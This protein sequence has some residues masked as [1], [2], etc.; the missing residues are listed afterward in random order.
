[1]ITLYGSFAKKRTG[2]LLT[3]AA[4]SVLVSFLF[5]ASGCGS[6]T[7]DGI[8]VSGTVSAAEV[9]VS[10][11]TGGRITD[12]TVQEGV[13]VKRGE[14]L[15]RLDSKVQALQVN[16]AE[17]G[18]RAAVEKARETKSGSREQLIAQAEFTVNQFDSLQQGARHTMQNAG[19]TL[20]RLKR[21]FA[22]GGATQQQL[23][24]AETGLAAAKAQ[25]ESFAS[26]KGSA[27]KQ[28][29]LLKNGATKE[30]VNIADAGVE[31]A[32]AELEIARANLEKT[33]LC[34]PVDGIISS[35]NFNNGEVVA[36]GAGLVSVLVNRDLWIDVYVSETELPHIKLGQQAEIS[37]DAFPE[38]IFHGR[39]A[40]I[41]PEAEFT[42]KN[43]QTKDERVNMVF[44]VKIMVTDGNDI[45]K[46]GLPADVRILTSQEE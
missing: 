8:H 42:P 46:P 11:E 3:G 14:V 39:A 43:L 25:Y 38:K 23:S 16:K 17:A 37:I 13:Y 36:P 5:T 12:I 26:Q 34:A 22:E 31:L 4:L 44:A 45:F 30:T 19:E 33:I 10:A 20:E 21:L 2:I 27:E 9:T 7:D 18:L 24:D 28:L 6:K 29:E 15:G 40:F 35:V 41:S 32:Q 1:M